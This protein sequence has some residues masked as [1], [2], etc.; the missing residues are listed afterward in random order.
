MTSAGADE[1][2]TTT[3]CNLAV[4]VAQAALGTSVKVPLL[5]GGE[6]ELEIEPKR[7]RSR[8]KCSLS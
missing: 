7:K 5:G 3:L 1:G 6:E 2:K 4:T 8:Q